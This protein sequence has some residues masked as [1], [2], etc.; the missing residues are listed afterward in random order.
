MHLIRERSV[1]GR[2]HL[3][4]DVRCRYRSFVIYGNLIGNHFHVMTGR[5]YDVMEIVSVAI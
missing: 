5:A 3:S 4:A 2:V 1:S